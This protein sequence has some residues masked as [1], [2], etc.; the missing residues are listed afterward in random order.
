MP[1]SDNPTS[2]SGERPATTSEAFDRAREAVAALRGRGRQADGTAGSGNTLNL[3]HGLRSNQLR[4]QP[5]VATWHRAQVD[6]ISADLGGA[7][8]LSALQH[9]SV[10]E[11][12]R[13]E[14]IVAALGDQLLDG[15]VLTGKGRIR[16]ARLSICK[17]S[18]DSSSWQA[19][20][21]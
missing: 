13:L 21:A 14:V 5:D 8:E 19:Q 1:I 17:Y 15:G 20:S 4:E 6:A 16:S 11:V 10:R 2:P 12:A 3:R 18:I 9:A 7:A